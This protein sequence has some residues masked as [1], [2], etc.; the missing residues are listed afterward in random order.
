MI[1]M[2]KTRLLTVIPFLLVVVLLLGGPTLEGTPCLAQGVTLNSKAEEHVY[3]GKILGVSRK[4]KTI[5]I[6]VDGK[7]E[8]VNFDETTAGLGYAATDEA[9]IIT[10]AMREGRKIATDIQQKLVQLPE[11]LTEMTVDEV[12]RLVAMGPEKGNY[13]LVDA[14]PVQ[15]YDEGHIPT[16]V[17]IPVPVIEETK[18]ALFPGDVKIKNTTL[19]FYCGSPT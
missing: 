19:I 3:T 18:D 8:M 11:G 10:F 16:A 15:R 4:A 2:Q 17:S 12:A 6:E 9:A 7:P 1:C 5:T 13:F 14:R